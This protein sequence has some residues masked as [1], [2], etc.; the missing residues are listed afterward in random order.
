MYTFSRW[1]AAPEN[2]AAWIAVQRVAD[3]VCSDR[4]RREANPLFLHG[5]TGTGKTHLVSALVTEVAKR[6]RDRIIRMVSAD[7]FSAALRPEINQ[8]S[9]ADKQEAVASFSRCDLLVIDDVRH[10]SLVV[11][12]SF[13][14]LI[15]QRLARHLQMVFTA[16]AGPAHLTRF[17][18]RLTSRLASGLVVG[19]SPLCPESRL[20]FLHDRAQ[21]RH[22]ALD[23][24]VLTW[25]AKHVAGSGR[26]LE[27][28]LGRLETVAK[29]NKR[30]PDLAAVATL[31]RAEADHARPT[32]E[33]IA[34]R[35]GS[36]FQVDAGDLQ[37]RRRCRNALLPRQI[38][39]YLARR[40]TPLS[41]GQIGNYFGGRDHST[42]LHACR[43]VEK[44]MTHDHALSG[45]V[46]QLHADLA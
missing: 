14:G 1:V 15:D 39:M 31:F 27:G 24:D 3:C 28:A 4:Q 38:G 19:L 10:L 12:E 2:R 40:L 33:R 11:A 32:V 44:A 29:L 22:L 46:R 30:L 36:Y 35:V 16:S 41:L 34:S 25:L 9:E 42:V 8:M 37:S 21:R 20:V 23:R 6:R 5:P 18:A 43:K 26:Q 13:V 45:A 17:P 7:E